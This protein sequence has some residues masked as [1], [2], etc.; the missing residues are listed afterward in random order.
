MVLEARMPT[1]T[2]HVIGFPRESTP[3][4]RRTLLTP[5]VASLLREAGFEVLAER[6]IAVGVFGDDADLGASGVR[7]VG[8]DDVWTVP[9]V[10]RYKNTCATDL[11]RLRPGQTIAALFHAEGDRELLT[12]LVASGATAYSYEFVTE[13]G[14]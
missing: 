3:D 2:Q 1:P 14:R 9:L 8:P 6:G 4:D 11:A 5:S 10:L 13:D 12:A 7:F